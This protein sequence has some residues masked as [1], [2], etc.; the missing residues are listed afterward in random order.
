MGFRASTLAP[1]SY[2]MFFAPYERIEER[3]CDERNERKKT[4]RRARRARG[5]FRTY[6]RWAG[7]TPM[8]VVMNMVQQQSSMA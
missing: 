4:R 5:Y 8:A 3:K 2:I 7:V 1:T 6:V